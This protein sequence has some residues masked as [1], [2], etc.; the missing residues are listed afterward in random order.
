MTFHLVGVPLSDVKP[1][2]ISWLWPGRIPFGKL[3]VIDG[4]PGVAKSMLTLD[5]AARISRGFP[6]P[7]GVPVTT[8]S[9]L[10][11]TAED[12]LADTVRP[13][14]D[15]MGADVSRVH[16]I[17]STIYQDDPAELPVTLPTHVEAMREY[18]RDLGA[19]LVVIDPLM[20]YLSTEV[21]SKIDHD[22]RRVLAPI[23]QLADDTGAAIVVVRHLN[24]STG[25]AAIYRGGGSIGIIGAARAGLLVAKDPNDDTR[26]ILAVIKCNLSRE[27]PSLRFRVDTAENHAARIAWEG[28]ATER[29]R[30]LLAMPAEDDDRSALEQ[31][32]AYGRE[33][34]ANGAVLVR[35][36]EADAHAAGISQRTL[37]RARRILGV[38]ATKLNGQAGKGGWVVSLPG[39]RPSTAYGAPTPPPLPSGTLDGDGGNGGFPSTSTFSAKRA[40]GVE[41]GG[42]ETPKVQNSP[43]HLVGGLD[44]GALPG[45]GRER[46]F[47]KGDA[48]E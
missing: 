18:V 17:R 26:R 39:Y 33:S 5:L 9:V 1:E 20:A 44:S 12:G 15:A 45:D 48:A 3:T 34:L 36:W 46:L 14:L 10:I 4:D 2:Q 6:L 7:D 28:E 21:D 42:V 19:T 8:G 32:V 27:S 47:G 22:V 25:A 29:A 24:K 30:E 43:E 31:A 40:T 13:R 11:F 37:E 35:H 41:G 16:A 23:A 38:R